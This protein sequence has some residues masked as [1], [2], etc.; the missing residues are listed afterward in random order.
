[1]C[2]TERSIGYTFLSNLFLRSFRILLF[3]IF[4]LCRLKH[5]V[6]KPIKS[7]IARPITTYSD[8]VSFL[9]RTYCL[10][11][12]IVDDKIQKKCT[13]EMTSNGMIYELGLTSIKDGRQ[14][15]IFFFHGST[16]P[17][18]P[19]PPDYRGFTITIR[20]NTLSWI[21]LNNL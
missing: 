2:L 12:G 5:I 10:L 3:L 18:G 1:M 4:I 14:T 21:P 17:S 20:H 9:C 8:H 7:D 15:H 16:A 19:R 6:S 13:S 11:I